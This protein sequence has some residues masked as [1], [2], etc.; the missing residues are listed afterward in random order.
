MVTK[1]RYGNGWKLGLGRGVEYPE[2]SS[3]R[4][5]KR[6]IHNERRL[7]QDS[8]LKSTFAHA[9]TNDSSNVNEANNLYLN[10]LISVT[11]YGLNKQKLVQKDS[12]NNTQKSKKKSK[13]YRYRS[14]YYDFIPDNEY[15]YI[16]FLF[17]IGIIIIGFVLWALYSLIR[18]LVRALRKDKDLLP[19]NSTASPKSNDSLTAV[20][21][22]QKEN[23]VNQETTF[24]GDTTFDHSN[25]MAENTE[26][27]ADIEEDNKS[28]LLSFLVVVALALGLVAIM[29]LGLQSQ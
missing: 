11:S 22:N 1:C 19:D 6:D 15:E 16:L 21:P 12:T 17:L 3:I 8:L 4:K 25:E 9:L 26:E 23:N 5:S 7:S 29:A 2:K 14:N 28:K 13:R 18:L 10:S 20:D 24:E 27:N